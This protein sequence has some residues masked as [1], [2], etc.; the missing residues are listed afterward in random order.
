M[1]P[2]ND[3]HR[4]KIGLGPLMASPAVHSKAVVQLLFVHCLLLL[5]L[6]VGVWYIGYLL[7]FAVYCGLSSFAIIS[8]GKSELVASPFIS[9]FVC[10]R[11]HIDVVLLWLFL[12]VL[13]V[14]LQYVI[15]AFL[16][17]IFFLSLSVYFNM[18][19]FIRI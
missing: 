1:G 9:F 12:A 7:Y 13:W 8:Q 17:V 18:P 5:S 19:S 2:A 14:G 3:K 10:F 4:A 15:A 6:F 16:G 11:C